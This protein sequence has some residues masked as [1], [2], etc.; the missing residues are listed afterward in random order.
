MSVDGY[1]LV[2]GH[3]LPETLM[4]ALERIGTEI[5]ANLIQSRSF[6]KA[7]IEKISWYLSDIN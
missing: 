2:R 3:A 6:T 7:G 4:G 5:S 1:G